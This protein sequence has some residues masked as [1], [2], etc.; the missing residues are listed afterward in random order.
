MAWNVVYYF[1]DDESQTLRLGTYRRLKDETRVQLID[2]F[3]ADERV[4]VMSAVEA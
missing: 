3:A 2:R 4:V 1:A